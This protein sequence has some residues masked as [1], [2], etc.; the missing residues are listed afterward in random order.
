LSSSPRSLSHQCTP[1]LQRS[2]TRLNTLHTAQCNRDCNNNQTSTTSNCLT[3][4]NRWMH[5][6]PFSVAQ[7]IVVPSSSPPF[8]H[9]LHLCHVRLTPRVRCACL[10]DAPHYW[11]AQL[12]L[13]S[14]MAVSLFSQHWFAYPWSTF[15]SAVRLEK[16]DKR[17]KE[18]GGTP[19][20]KMGV[21]AHDP[22]HA[23]QCPWRACVLRR[24]AAGLFCHPSR[25]L[26][27]L[28]AVDCVPCPMLK[29]SQLSQKKRR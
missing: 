23:F 9:F 27:C 12:F 6:Y 10:Q 7:V 1:R 24:F 26:M 17:G 20:K 16:Q 14:C 11:D 5:G 22:P 2:H 8:S 29:H 19:F 18:E 15:L 4:T 25:F 21:P 13:L 3:L 28:D